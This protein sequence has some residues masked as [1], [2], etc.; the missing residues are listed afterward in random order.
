MCARNTS[1]CCALFAL[2]HFSYRPRPALSPSRS[3]EPRA[4][5]KSSCRRTRTQQSDSSERPTEQRSTAESSETGTR[6]PSARRNHRTDTTSALAEVR[7][8]SRSTQPDDRHGSAI[9]AV[10]ISTLSA[11]RQSAPLRSLS[12][13]CRS[14]PRRSPSAARRGKGARPR[15]PSSSRSRRGAASSRVNR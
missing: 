2:S 14:C 3:R 1:K 4:N 11:T 10:V 8:R 13:K 12:S 5:S 7:P 9:P 6:R 15:T